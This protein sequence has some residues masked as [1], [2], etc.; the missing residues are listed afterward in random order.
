MKKLSTAKVA[1]PYNG[2]KIKGELYCKL[3]AFSISAYK[4]VNLRIANNAVKTT[5][6]IIK[7]FT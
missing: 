2:T 5:N 7:V 4:S 1:N 6:D 3:R